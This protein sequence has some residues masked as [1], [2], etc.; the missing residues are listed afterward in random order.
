METN[1][2]VMEAPVTTRKPRAARAAIIPKAREEDVTGRKPIRFSFYVEK[3]CIAFNEIPPADARKKP[4]RVYHIYPTLAAWVGKTMPDGVNPRSHDA[5]C[6]KS[7]VARQ[8]ENKILEKPDNFYLANR[9]IT[10]MAD[11]V[12]HTGNICEIVITDPQQQGAADGATTDAVISKVQTLLARELSEDKQIFY[13]QFLDGITSGNKVDW[14]KIPDVLR[15]ARVHLEV[16]VGLEDRERIADLVEGRNTSRQVKG[17]SM[18][19][20]KGEFDDLKGILERDKSPFKG[21]IGWEE[22]SPQDVNVLDVLSLLTL[23][24]PEFDEQDE[25]GK[26]KAPVVAYAN[27]GRMD[28]RLADEDLRKAYKRLNPL[29]IDIL[30]LYEFMYAE[31]EGAYDAAF[32]NKSRLGKREGVTPRHDNPVVLPLTG[33]KANYVIP[34]GFLFPLLASFRALVTY[35]PQTGWKA[36]P[37]EFFRKHGKKLVAELMDQVESVGGNPNVAGKKKQV[38]T[39]MHAQTRLALSRELAK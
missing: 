22:N 31:F 3:S 17:W 29:V 23:M 6:L 12:N 1:T 25:Q 36:D 10:I 2:A 33:F 9:G 4:D 14:D 16:H 11:A 7:P 30:K 21:L 26:D 32:G 18:A 19:D 24:H 38:Y 27:K 39:A 34:N 5:D 20:F 13:G 28:S 8:I 35:T 37:Y 15:K